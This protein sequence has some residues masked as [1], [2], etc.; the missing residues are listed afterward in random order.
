MFGARSVAPRPAAWHD[1]ASSFTEV[2]MRVEW[3]GPGDGTALAALVA[4]EGDAR[5]R[6]RYRVVLLAGRG[7]GDRAELTREQIADGVGRS[8]QFVDEW[9]GRYRTGGIGAL[10]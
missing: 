7:L 3:K 9:V 4:G 6:D 8:R 1:D 10:A 5:Q 2:L